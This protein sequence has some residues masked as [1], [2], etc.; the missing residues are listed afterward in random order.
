[1][2]VRRRPATVEA[3]VVLAV[4]DV[5]NH[6]ARMGEGLARQAGLTT[7][8]WLALLQVDGDPHFA[9]PP[10]SDPPGR[11]L[12]SGIARAR[13]VSRPS[14]HAV[15]S[16]LTRR[17]LLVQERDPGD[18]RRRRLALTPAGRRALAAVEPA[19]RRANR[20]F[21]AGLRPG[22]RRRLLGY[23]QTC[24]R[25]LWTDSRRTEGKAAARPR[26]RGMP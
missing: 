6:L 26:R 9:R 11:L 13:G 21:L 25:R 12:A 3:A 15:V 24:L 17:R 8:Q 1:M 23:L 20:A 7:R 5:A 4:M 19:R 22:E 14:V 18:G 10:G 16:E 2:S